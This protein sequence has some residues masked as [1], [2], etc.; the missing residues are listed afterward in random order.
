MPTAASADRG[1]PAP[2][3][4]RPW[5]RVLAA[6]VLWA[7]AA[8]LAGLAVSAL[9][10]SR[11]THGWTSDTPASQVA[12]SEVVV[13]LLMAVGVAAVGWAA[14]TSRGRMWTPSALLQ[15]FALV[16]AWPLLKSDQPG[17]RIMGVLT[18]VVALVGAVALVQ[19]ARHEGTHG[20]AQSRA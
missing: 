14:M 6:V 7:E 3:Q 16:A 5:W 20:Q 17:Y 12:V 13:Y 19:W 10:V 15:A 8:G 18:A 4:R 11:H 2:G 1:R 9:I